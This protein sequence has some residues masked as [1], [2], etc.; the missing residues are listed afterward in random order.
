MDNHNNKLSNTCEE[1]LKLG[2]NHRYVKCLSNEL[3]ASRSGLSSSYK[4]CYIV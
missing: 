2:H 3:K 1:N 4:K